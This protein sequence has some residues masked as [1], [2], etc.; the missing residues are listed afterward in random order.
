MQCEHP[1]GERSLTGDFLR[2]VSLLLARCVCYFEWCA[3]IS[4]LHP[5]GSVQV[6]ALKARSLWMKLMEAMEDSERAIAS[7]IDISMIV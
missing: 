7:Q 4:V 5:I 1:E 3:F 2:L 6:E